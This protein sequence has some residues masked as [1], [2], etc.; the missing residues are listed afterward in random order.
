[1]LGWQHTC[2][3]H[4]VQVELKQQ[5]R[6]A[7]AAWHAAQTEDTQARLRELVQRMSE[8][9][10]REAVVEGYGASAAS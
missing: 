3:L 8:T 9:D 6:A 2:A 5:I 7:E 1:M 4:G 10:G